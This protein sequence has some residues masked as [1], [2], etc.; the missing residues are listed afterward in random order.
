IATL[1]DNPAMTVRPRLSICVFVSAACLFSQPFGGGSQGPESDLLRQGQQRLR[2]DQTDE[3]LALYKQ[4]I[5]KFPQ[6]AAA[7]SQTGGLPGLRG[8]DAGARGHFQKAL[9]L[10]AT[11]QAK[12]QASRQMAMSYAFENNCKQAEKYETLWYQT[13]LET[14]DYFNAGEAANELARVCIE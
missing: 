13:S 14:Q 9:E 12:A 3:A 11:P 4:A 5:E 6:A 2:E 7:Q 10:A 8:Q 1:C